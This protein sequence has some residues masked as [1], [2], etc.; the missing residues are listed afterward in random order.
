M[1]RSTVLTGIVIAICG[2]LISAPSRPGLESSPARDIAECRP[3]AAET[4]G[5]VDAAFAIDT[6]RST[7]N[8]SGFDVNGNGRV[9]DLELSEMTDPGDSLLAA[10]IAGIRSLLLETAELDVR[11]S[12]V[13]F[14][15][16]Y[17][18]TPRQR[19]KHIVR[20]CDA[21]VRS[22]LTD[23]VGAL[24]D[25]LERV[26]GR[27]STGYTDFAAGMRQ[28]V[29]TLADE[30][31]PTRSSRRFV[32]FISDSTTPILIGGNERILRLDPLMEEVAREAIDSRIVFN[33]FGLGEAAG[34]APPH[35]LSRIATATGGT[36]RAVEDP[37]K[38]ACHLLDSL[39]IRTNESDGYP[40]D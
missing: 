6:S 21:A 39:A 22:K 15:G 33:T 4:I 38:L 36:Y 7:V 16:S 5:S 20:D 13:T 23:D 24:E 40:I 14:S 34:A 10:E 32:L 18:P 28:A 31:P 9:G 2:S 11:F 37:T 3:P 1:R 26:L 29:R 19:T 8:P 25:A 12:I 35:T 27:G 30:P 17:D